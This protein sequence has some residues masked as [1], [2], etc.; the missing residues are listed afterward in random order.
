MT[1]TATARPDRSAY[2]QAYHVRRKAARM[3]EFP[4]PHSVTLPGG[5]TNY[6]S[7]KWAIRT[8]HVALGRDGRRRN[9][10][11]DCLL[12]LPD[13]IMTRTMRRRV[14]AALARVP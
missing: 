14:D 13:K 1:A 12:D 5:R 11:P 2:M 8:E 3:V 9:M 6:A 7:R 4:K 10:Y